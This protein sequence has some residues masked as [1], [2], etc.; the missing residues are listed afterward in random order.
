MQLLPLMERDG[1]SGG[2]AVQLVMVPLVVG[3]WVTVLP[4][5]SMSV[6][7]LKA[8]TGTGVDITARFRIAVANPVL[9]EAV[10]T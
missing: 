7:G 5:V 1:G 10:M 2:L 6:P 3:V 8:T 9:F 4:T